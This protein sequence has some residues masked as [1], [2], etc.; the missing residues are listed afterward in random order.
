MQNWVTLAAIALTLAAL[1]SPALA[2]DFYFEFYNGSTNKIEST[3]PLGVAVE[4]IVASKTQDVTKLLP[5]AIVIRADEDRYKNAIPNN[6]EQFCRGPDGCSI[7]GPN[8]PQAKYLEIS[9]LTGSSEVLT[10]YTKG[11]PPPAA[12]LEV[13]PS[14]TTVLAT[15]VS[16]P[17]SNAPA[18]SET[19]QSVATSMPII[20]DPG[21]DELVLTEGN[22]KNEVLAILVLILLIG[23]GLGIFL[24]V[25]RE[26]CAETCKVGECQSCELNSLIVAT[27]GKNKGEEDDLV[28][29]GK[30]LLDVLS[31]AP[32]PSS[33]SSGKGLTGGVGGIVSKPVIKEGLEKAAEVLKRRSGMGTWGVDIWARLELVKCKQVVCWPYF[34]R[35]KAEWDSEF[36][37]VKIDPP[38]AFKLK[39]GGS[40]VGWNYHYLFSPDA[41]QRRTIGRKIRELALKH[42]GDCPHAGKV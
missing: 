37:E 38:D 26:D 29:L 28:D 18:P 7:P 23:A 30:L 22:N 40:D 27:H 32:L 34:W 36:I 19:S 14:P 13:N 31:L 3:Y 17:A 16:V 9:A 1:P 25:K 35:N 15:P 11:T 20:P 41:N 4:I 2:A 6:P 24:S 33:G 21:A 8:I 12:A 42:C 39:G 10:T 5:I